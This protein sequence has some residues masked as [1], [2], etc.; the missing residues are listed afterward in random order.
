MENSIRSSRKRFNSAFPFVSTTS[1]KAPEVREEFIALNADLAILAFVSFI[2][3]P[4]VFSV[5]R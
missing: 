5:P 4:Q 3:P 2:V 1:F